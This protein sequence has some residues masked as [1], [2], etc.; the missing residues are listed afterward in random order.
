MRVVLVFPQHLRLNNPTTQSNQPNSTHPIKLPPRP[1]PL[2]PAKANL[3]RTPHHASP[4]QPRPQP[5][6]RLALSPPALSRRRLLPAQHAAAPISRRRGLQAQP[7]APGKAERGADWWSFFALRCA[8]LHFPQA[9][10]C[11]LGSFSRALTRLY[12][13]TGLRG[14]SEVGEGTCKRGLGAWRAPVFCF[15]VSFWRA[16]GGLGAGW[17]VMCCALLCCR[18]AG[19]LHRWMWMG[20]TSGRVVRCKP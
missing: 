2:S 16:R 5:C 10:L 11:T 20:R 8:A 9:C 15:L 4:T 3:T 7:A 18:R 17:R 1:R 14:E 19:G 12:I 13:R 6:G